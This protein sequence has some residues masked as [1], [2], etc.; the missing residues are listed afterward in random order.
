MQ[1]WNELE[2]RV[3][4]GVYPLRRLTRSEG[5][6]AWFETESGDGRRAV[7]S[8]TESLTDVE[9]VVKRLEAAQGLQDPNLVAIF[10]VGRARFE[11]TLFVYALMEHTEQNL[12]EVLR[13]QPLSK[14]DVQQVAEA[15][16]GAL[17][18]IHQHGLL[19]GRVEPDSVFA[20]GETVKLR[21]DCLQ[22]PG[23]TRAGDV[24]GI[25]A[26]IFQ[27]FTQRKAEKA[28]DGQIN[29]LPAPFAEIVRNS[30]SSRWSLGQVAAA[31]RP[32]AA[33]AAAPAAAQ[34]PRAA[35]PTIPAR[36]EPVAQNPVPARQAST[37][38]EA[39]P[40]ARTDPASV[41]SSLISSIEEEEEKE[42]AAVSKSFRTTAV[43]IALAVVVLVVVVWL[44]FRP[45]TNSTAGNPPVSPPAS[46]LAAAPSAAPSQEPETRAPAAE[47]SP[48]PPPS[49][50]PAK[51]SASRRAPTQAVSP[52]AAAVDTRA[53]SERLVWHVIAY[54]YNR[55]DQ[56]QRKI[57]EI[58]QEH[59][60]LQASIL[61]IS[62]G[63]RPHFLVTIGGPMSRDQAIALR[64]KAAALGLPA[65]S[66]VQNF[67]H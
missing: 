37:A 49:T 54:T 42:D 35:A 20:V 31:L 28:D 62:A 17:T 60:D 10:K 18:T 67:S 50:Q 23:S 46:S 13:E 47:P 19:H 39:P 27:A 4:D 43:Y 15:L 44:A 26:T 52:A 14:E 8:L 3:F 41:S 21:S 11:K 61:S 55:Q 40:A 2:G 5:R 34:T 65:D 53:P 51:P 58:S 12:S 33:G 48:A 6:T 63:G 59:A 24:A 64:D 38:R 36:A 32:P 45:K 9:E 56:A 30:L 1:F 16:V 22:S 57:D 25:G 29:R 66:Y 7:I